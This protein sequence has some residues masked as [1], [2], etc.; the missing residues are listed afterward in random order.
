MH[1]LIGVIVF[2][3]DRDGA[4][5]EAN[6]VLN[7]LCENGHPFDYFSL[8]DGIW[9]DVPLVIEADSQEGR[10]VIERLWS[11][12]KTEL[13]E[14][15]EMARLA[16]DNLTPDQIIEEEIPPEKV[17]KLSG[18]LGMPRFWF[19]KVGA[20]K[21]PSVYLYDK[22]GEGIRSETHLKNCLSKW[23]CLYGSNEENPYR[24]LTSFVVTADVH[25]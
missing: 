8:N 25:Y 1:M 12:T 14:A 10:R 4:L 16:L 13:L 2:S 3:L 18:L 21:G 7:G 15:I 22:D 17:T 23:S 20:F 19:Q 5:I 6:S 9:E 11:E 24:D